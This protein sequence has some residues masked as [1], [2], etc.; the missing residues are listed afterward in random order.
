[1]ESSLITKFLTHFNRAT[2]KVWDSSSKDFEVSLRD[3][4]A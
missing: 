2:L 1:M 4:F 3:H